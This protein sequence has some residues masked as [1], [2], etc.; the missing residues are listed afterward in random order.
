LKSL[1][2]KLAQG[3]EPVE[4]DTEKKYSFYNEKRWAFCA[5]VVKDKTPIGNVY[6]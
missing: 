3:H 5:S 6:E 2:A 1:K 4:W